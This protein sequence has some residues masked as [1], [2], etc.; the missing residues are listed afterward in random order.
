MSSA[1]ATKEKTLK[2]LPKVFAIHNS[3]NISLLKLEI[4]ERKAR[5]MILISAD[6]CRHDN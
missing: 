5:T 4:N 2:T 3:E 1:E 6:K